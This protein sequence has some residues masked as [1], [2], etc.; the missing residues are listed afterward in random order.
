[1][2][3]IVNPLKV[4]PTVLVAA[5]GEAEGARGAAA[6]LA[7]AVADSD[8]APLMIDVGGRAPRPTLVTSA[9]AQQLEGR[10]ETHLPDA[11]VAARGQVCHLAVPADAEALAVAS[12]AVATAR[13]T[14]V[15]VHVPSELLQEA[16][17]EPTLP[18]SA[19][20]L[21]ANLGGDRALVALAVRDL[22]E[23]GLS[24]AVLKHRLS[25]VAERRALFGLL[26]LGSSGGL[27]DR[28]VRRL[29][30]VAR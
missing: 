27:P 16:L 30:Q 19:V 8:A 11:K 17:A 2:T 21:R 13:E 10:L 18:A 6:A 9:A 5:V 3:V 20:L 29:T 23:R 24:A 26:P 1:M 22:V 15:V 12:R 4:A 25:W 7:C 28:I 14:G